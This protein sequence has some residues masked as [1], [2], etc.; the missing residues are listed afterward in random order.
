MA[1]RRLTTPAL[2][3][4][5]VVHNNTRAV[6]ARTSMDVWKFASPPAAPRAPQVLLI[7][8]TQGSVGETAELSLSKFGAPSHA[9]LDQC[10]LRTIDRA[11]D[12]A[13]FDGWRQGSLRNIAKADLGEL[14][15]LDAADHAHV[16]ICAPEAPAD[17]TY[18]QA[19]WAIARFVASRGPATVLDAHAM[20]FHAGDKLQPAGAPLEVPREV[21]VVYETDP[22]RADGAHALHTRGLK[23]FGAPDL[24]ALCTDADARLVGH[25]MAELADTVARGTDLASPKHAVQVAPGVTWFA[26]AD[27]HRLGDVLQLNNDARVLVDGA[28]HDLVGVMTRLPRARD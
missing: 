3:C 4:S 20:M 27:E 23:K 19:A 5:L 13:W 26:V 28:G 18:L 7:V 16:I 22:S 1:Q 24:V 11:A 10:S 17:L 25:A 6:Y 15:T 8:F 12:A 14:A 21:R 9:A 2:K